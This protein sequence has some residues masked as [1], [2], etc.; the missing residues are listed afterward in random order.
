MALVKPQFEAGVERLPKDGVVKDERVR[1]DILNEV[2]SFAQSHGWQF[3]QMEIS[4]IQG[5]TGNVEF[6]VHFTRA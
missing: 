6:L 2:I 5:K 3:H 1:A 4:P